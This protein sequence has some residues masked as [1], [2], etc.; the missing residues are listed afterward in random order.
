MFLI[1]VR[2]AKTRG[3]GSQHNYMYKEWEKARHVWQQLAKRDVWR[4]SE[5]DYH[6]PGLRFHYV[7]TNESLPLGIHV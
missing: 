2:P 4:P 1:R 3:L 6:A 7:A 5:A